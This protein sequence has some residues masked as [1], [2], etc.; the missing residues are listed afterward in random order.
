MSALTDTGVRLHI[1]GELAA[2][3]AAPT[4]HEAATALGLGAGEVEAA[5]R[6][7]AEGRV[8]VLEPGSTDIWMANPFS[9]RPTPFRVSGGGRSWWGVCVWDSPGILAMLGIDGSI[10][11]TCPDCDDPLEL[12]VEGG[13]L[14]GP[15]GAVAHFAVPAARWWDD[16][17]F[18]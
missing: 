14:S 1:Y 16:I 17:G 2:G 10:R 7:L 13:E 11:T 12:A 4:V 6:R 18:T 5:Y 15:P 3:R 9:T 8:V